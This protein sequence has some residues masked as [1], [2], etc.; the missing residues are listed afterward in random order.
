MLGESFPQTVPVRPV[1]LAIAA[2]FLL[3]GLIVAVNALRLV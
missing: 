2:A 3:L 1:R